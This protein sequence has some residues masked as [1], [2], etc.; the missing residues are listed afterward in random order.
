MYVCGVQ[1]QQPS[2]SKSIEQS[3]QGR[4]LSL[5]FYGLV[6][7]LKC[8]AVDQLLSQPRL[9]RCCL[10]W[11]ARQVCLCTNSWMQGKLPDVAFKDLLNLLLDFF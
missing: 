7:S 9:A 5:A 6:S 8:R 4:L 2:G 1:D 3:S 11:L 10:C